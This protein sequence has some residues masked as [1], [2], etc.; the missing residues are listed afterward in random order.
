MIFSTESQRRLIWHG[1]FLFLLG[2][3][4]GFAEGQVINPRMALAAHLE[5]LMNG[6]FPI[7]LG[8]V[9]PHV[10]LP[11]RLTTGTYWTALYGTYSNVIITTFAAVVGANSLSPI[12]GVGHKAMAWQES[13]VTV[14]FGAVGSDVGIIGSDLVGIAPNRSRTLNSIFV[15]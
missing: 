14:G 9:W 13:V 5:G 1:M 15:L 4:I 11:S 2:L 6:T 8:A 7:A 10:R 12:T 3:L